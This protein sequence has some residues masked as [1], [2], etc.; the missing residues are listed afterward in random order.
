MTDIDATPTEGA[1]KAKRTRK[2]SALSPAVKSAQT[3]AELARALNV[4]PK[5]FRAWLRRTGTH[6][7]Q[8]D[9]LDAK[10]KARAVARYGK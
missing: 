6:L 10:T 1:P 4:A 7:S 8:G 2:A 3:G 9:K 5:A